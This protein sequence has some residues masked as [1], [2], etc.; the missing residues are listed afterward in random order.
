MT[1]THRPIGGSGIPR[2]KGEDAIGM[3][4]GSALPGGV[5]MRTRTRVG[6]AVRREEDGAIVTEGFDIE[7]PSSR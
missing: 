1:R 2:R 5:M 6:V 3:V 4:G 7:P